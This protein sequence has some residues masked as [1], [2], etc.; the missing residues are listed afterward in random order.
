MGMS[1]PQPSMWYHNTLEQV[2]PADPPMQKI[3]PLFDTDRIRTLC[4]RVQGGEA[5]ELAHSLLP[6]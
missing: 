5:V 6:I 4:P 3:R 1:D 2:V